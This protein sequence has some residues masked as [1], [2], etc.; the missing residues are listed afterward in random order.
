[1]AVLHVDRDRA[2]REFWRV[3]LAQQKG[4]W[5]SDQRKAGGQGDDTGAR[6]RDAAADD[7]DDAEKPATIALYFLN[8]RQRVVG[9]AG[10][11]HRDVERVR[12]DHRVAV[13][14]FRSGFRVAG[15]AGQLFDATRADKPGDE[16]G[17][18]AQYADAPVGQ[19]IARFEVE[20]TEMSGMKAVVEASLEGS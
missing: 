20:S 1:M 3:R 11:A 13:A 6:P 18:A 4:I 17:T 7:G 15:Y 9:F 19:Q 5:G 12:L 8:R 2:D 14:E 10:L 16:G